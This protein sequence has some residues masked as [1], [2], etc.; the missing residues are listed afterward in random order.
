MIKRMLWIIASAFFIIAVVLF[1]Y[2]IWDKIPSIR[3]SSFV[4]SDFINL[5]TAILTLL[6]LAIAIGSLYIAISA[7]QKSVNDSQEQQKSLDDSRDQ[8]KAVVNAATIQQEVLTKN[9]EISKTQLAILEEQWRREQERQARK[10]IAEVNLITTEGTRSLDI[11]EK[12]EEIP[13]F[14]EKDSRDSKLEFFV[15]NKGN[16]EISKPIVRIVASNEKVFVDKADFRIRVRPDHNSFQ[17]SGPEI[18]DINPIE[19]SGPY[20]FAVVITVPDSVN[21]FDLTFFIQGNNL[22]RKVHTL[23]LKVKSPSS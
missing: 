8:L 10:P 13:L 19:V 20:R 14:I 2:L 21:A 4:L 23:H 22:N 9:L 7:Y 15:T 11:L 5:F 18:N 3:P 17:F 6:G 16:A 1:I 12:M